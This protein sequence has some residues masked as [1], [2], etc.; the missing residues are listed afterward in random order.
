MPPD[1]QPPAPPAGMPSEPS[2]PSAPGSQGGTYDFIVNP[3]KPKIGPGFNLPGS[4]VVRIVYIAG[5]LLLL[6]II[7]SVVKGQFSKSNFTPYISII[8]DQQAMIHLVDSVN[9]QTNLSTGT[10]NFAVTT[11]LSLTSSRSAMV[12][13][14]ANN[15]KKVSDKVANLKISAS[16]DEQ[17]ANAN[18]AGT[19][20]QAFQGVMKN[21]LTS[22][23]NDLRQTYKQTKGKKGHALLQDDYNQAKLLMIQ[24]DTA[25]VQ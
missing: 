8:Q 20:E 9:N 21:K 7:F 10:Q 11:Q 6:L 14:L 2:Q 19:Y 16:V 23:L 17:L 4:P 22:Y 13:Y 24:L 18:S 3:S 25:Q 1:P 5:G 15:H 12:G